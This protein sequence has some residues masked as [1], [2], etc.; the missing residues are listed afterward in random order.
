MEWTFDFGSLFLLEISLIPC[1][2]AFL[3]TVPFSSLFTFFD[4][5]RYFRLPQCLYFCLIPPLALVAVILGGLIEQPT[6]DRVVISIGI[7]SF[8][9]I[10]RGASDSESSSSEKV[11]SRIGLVGAL[12]ILA[13]GYGL[14]LLSGSL[15]RLL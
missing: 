14:P 2:L 13:G 4:F 7:S 9:D 11:R 15:S 10:H 1:F 3:F 6:M 12:P 5:S 8:E